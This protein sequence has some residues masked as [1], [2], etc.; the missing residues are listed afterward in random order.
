MSQ[1]VVFADTS[2]LFP[3]FAP[4]DSAK[5]IC[6]EVLHDLVVQ[7]KVRIVTTNWVYNECLSKLRKYGISQCE[8]LAK[9]LQEKHISVIR[10]SEELESK[11]LQI[12]WTF[13]DK[14]WGVVDCVSIAVI[15]DQNI[16]HVFAIDEHFE[17]AGLIRLLKTDQSGKTTKNYEYLVFPIASSFH[18]LHEFESSSN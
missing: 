7:H 18:L 17:Q 11:G 8:R 13:R 9:L 15:R 12:F 3:L 6:T 4:S 10:V 5:E 16:V 14:N 1:R 2:A